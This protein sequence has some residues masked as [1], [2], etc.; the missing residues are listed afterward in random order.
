MDRLTLR[1]SRLMNS[2]LLAWIFSIAVFSF[3]PSA[4][5]KC[6]S[7]S[8]YEILDSVQ[9]VEIVRTQEAVSGACTVN[10]QVEGFG[11]EGSS[12]DEDVC[13]AEIGERM[14]LMITGTCCDQPPCPDV[15][16]G[17]I[18]F[19]LTDSR[20][21]AE[22]EAGRLSSL[23]D[24]A[25][26]LEDPAIDSVSKTRRLIAYLKNEMAN[27]RMSTTGLGGGVIDSDYIQE[28]IILS[29]GLVGDL[30]ILKESL[31][32]AE[33]EALSDRL[34]VALGLVGDREASPRLIQ[35]VG[36]S[37]HGFLRALAARALGD[38]EEI[39]SISTLK[40]ALKDPFSQMAS[41][42]LQGQFTSYPVRE[43]AA[44]AL[45]RLGLS[46]DKLETGW[47]VDGELLEP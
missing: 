34:V 18:A 35:I 26:I 29:L 33:D 9:T 3:N 2:M 37:Q 19:A 42:S 17:S 20:L 41:N 46:V 25:P 45:R 39:A 11:L 23:A 6:W 7:Y 10:V 15:I 31:E 36:V 22:E 38:L 47:K 30:A 16:G 40:K 1:R 44:G 28:Q 13:G 43:E 14:D 27:P 4:S 5:A 32:Q 12:Q 21:V 8:V 24:L